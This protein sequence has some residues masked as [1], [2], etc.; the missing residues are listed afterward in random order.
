MKN[1]KIGIAVSSYLLLILLSKQ[2]ELAQYLYNI[3]TLIYSFVFLYKIIRLVPQ[4]I[5]S[6]RLSVL[7]FTTLNIIAM[8]LPFTILSVALFVTVSHF[9]ETYYENN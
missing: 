3:I 6:I 4:E 2:Y 1:I 9:E 8:S 7:A 5:R